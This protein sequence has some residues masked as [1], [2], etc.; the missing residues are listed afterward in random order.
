[1]SAQH[2]P[3][4]WR[5]EEGTNLVW[6]ACNPDDTTSYGMGMPVAEAKVELNKTYDWEQSCVN[7]R[8]IAAAPDLLDA[9]QRMVDWAGDM[10]HTS[11]RLDVIVAR[12]AIAKATGAA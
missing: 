6:G 11:E 5:L 8:L 1:M 12:V 7:A 3:G 10:P 4:P 2:T 9:L